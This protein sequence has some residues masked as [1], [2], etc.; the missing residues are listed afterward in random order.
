MAR[1]WRS[2]AWTLA[3]GRLSVVREPANG[4]NG[5]ALGL[6]GRLVVCEQGSRTAAARAFRA[7]TRVTGE[8]ETVV[9]EW[10]G[11]ALNS[12][13][14]VV[15]KRDGT[16]W[17]TDPSYGHLQGFRPAPEVGDY[18][19]RHDPATGTTTVVADEFDKPNGLRFSPDE[20][21]LYVNDSGVNQEAGSHHPGRRHHIKAFEVADGRRLRSE[22]L[23]A[24]VAPGQPDGMKCDADGRVY[25]SSA[26]GVQVY[27]PTATTLG[28][29]SVPGAVNFCF[30]GPRAKRPLHHQ[31]HGGLRRG[32]GQ[33]EEPDH[34]R[35]SDT[36][37]HRRRRAPTRCIAAAEAFADERGH[38]VV[39][40]VVDP[41]GELIALRRTEGAQI[42]C[43]RVAVDKA[44]TA[45]IFVR[46]SREIEEQVTN[47]RLGALALHGARALTGGIPLKV[48]GEVVG[49]VGTSGET[50]DEDE[51]ISIAGA[52]AEF[53][54]A[55]V[56]ALTYE[57][58]RHVAEAVGAEAAPRG[59]APVVA[60][61]DAGGD[62][63]YLCGPTPP[64]WRASTWRPTRRARRRST[65]GRARTSRTRPPAA[66]PRRCTSRGPCRCRAA[67]RSSTTAR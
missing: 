22:R 50:P 39:V 8:D 19:Y 21:V 26:S 18:V 37:D 60:V 41:S 54:T 31:R 32:T 44:R 16:V 15:V 36:Q 3:D 23:F 38:R 35:R 51:A 27:D 63:V 55:E 57:G 25:V 56:P 48:G 43:S 59:V 64:R 28:E 47:G 61:V 11:L 29:I 42:A 58:A 6:D 13:N 40:A 66:G 9:D 17:F 14:D 46:P 33:R 34:G 52:A 62:L 4:A 67:C 2:S 20:S 65:A 53:S 7:S 30:G 5:M 1:T 49:A 12:P 24:V 10:A 45:A